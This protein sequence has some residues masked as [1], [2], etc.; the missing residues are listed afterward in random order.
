M[1]G[2]TFRVQLYGTI[3]Y[4]Y[5]RCAP[6]HVT[7][8]LWC[9]GGREGLNSRSR[10]GTII[11]QGRVGGGE[12]TRK[13]QRQGRRRAMR[14]TLGRGRDVL[15]RQ[16]ADVLLFH[17]VRSRHMS[18]LTPS[19]GNV[20][21]LSAESSSRLAEMSSDDG[22]TATAPQAEPSHALKALT[23]AIAPPDNPDFQLPPKQVEDLEALYELLMRPL[24]PLKTQRERVENMSRVNALDE[25]AFFE[26]RDRSDTEVHA[27]RI[28]CLGVQGYLDEAHAAFDTML[29]RDGMRPDAGC[30]AALAD[31]CARCGDVEAAQAVITK[32]K[33]THGL[34]PTAPIYTS[35]IGAHRR[36]GGHDPVEVGRAVISEVQRERVVEDAPLHTSI[37]TWLV[38]ERRPNDAWDAYHRMPVQADAVTFTAMFMACAQLDQLEQARRLQMDMRRHFLAPT[39][40]THN[41]FISVCAARTKSLTEL[42]KRK[43]EQLQRLNVD[44]D[45]RTPIQLANN[46]LQALLADGHAPDESTYLSLLRVASGAADVPRAQ[47]LLTRMLDADVRPSARHFH[48]LLH[49][50]IRG[51][52]YRPNT[53]SEMHLRVALAVPPSMQECAPRLACLRPTCLRSARQHPRP[54]TPAHTSERSSRMTT[55]YIRSFLSGGRAET[56]HHD[57]HV[58]LTGHRVGPE[59]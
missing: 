59:A 4:R 45:V 43:H 19:R 5:H 22:L 21:R 29:D 10:T 16:L 50:C 24:P 53:L 3:T 18:T 15:R 1:V 32:L 25:E 28:R 6:T 7:C 51:Q 54:P 14:G 38:A 26:R 52:R 36:A 30:F 13:N 17:P 48:Q 55:P 56:R 49:A 31:A 44:L 8:G 42:P 39:L 9:S 33:R 23:H 47:S 37:I 58:S 27:H 2:I 46:T 20:S 11:F 34:R 57:L 41:A 12:P 35:L 40:A